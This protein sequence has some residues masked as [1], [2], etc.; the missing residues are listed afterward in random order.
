MMVQD[1]IRSI[2]QF[3]ESRLTSL[4]S[5][6]D[7]LKELNIEG[8]EANL[9]AWQTLL[10]KLIQSET[11][12]PQSQISISSYQPNLSNYLALDKYGEPKNLG[13][14]I[15]ELIDKEVLI[16]YSIYMKQDVAFFQSGLKTYI[17]IKSWINWSR[18]SLFR[19]SAVKD[20]KLVDDR[21][22][23]VDELTKHGDYVFD[24]ILKHVDNS[25]ISKL[26]N[27]DL[28]LEF[29]NKYIRLTKIDLII[30]LKYWSR[31]KQLVQVNQEYIKIGNDPITE[32]DIK[33]I[34]MKLTIDKLSK[35]NELLESKLLQIDLKQVLKLPKDQ[36]KLK[37][38]QLLNEKK[39]LSLQLEKNIN[40]HAELDTIIDKINESTLNHEIF[41]QMVTS[42]S[43]LKKLNKKIDLNEVDKLKMD[44][45]EEVAKTE[46]INEALYNTQDADVDEELQQLITENEKVEK[47]DAEVLKKLS[48]LTVSDKKPEAE[49]ERT[50]KEESANLQLELN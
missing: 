33:L 46:E 10:I 5:K 42:S 1:F 20:G 36:Q 48:E 7:K 6:F 31:D 34:N 41:N 43:I 4:Y 3:K 23:S 14:I 12:L 32:D 40:I 26:F 50:K 38:K 11:Y 15:Q 24:I 18:R 21:L 47:E 16:P 39:M 22:I 19:Y 49:K 13:N 35:R 8:Y 37:L 9:T 25:C 17:S 30:L 44:I 29:I 28:L 27:E 45:D 2:P